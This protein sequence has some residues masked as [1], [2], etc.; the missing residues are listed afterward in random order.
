MKEKQKEFNL[1]WS[2]LNKLNF[3]VFPEMNPK[4]LLPEL[5]FSNKKDLEDFFISTYLL[6]RRYVETTKKCIFHQSLHWEMIYE[7]IYLYMKLLFLIMTLLYRSVMF[8]WEK[9]LKNTPL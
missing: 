2:K 6:D 9:K 1:G 8:S 3:Q 5:K 4:H 7:Y